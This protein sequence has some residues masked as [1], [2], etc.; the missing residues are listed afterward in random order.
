MIDIWSTKIF[1]NN[2]FHF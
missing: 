2:I 1:T